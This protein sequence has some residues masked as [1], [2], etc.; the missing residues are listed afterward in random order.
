MRE[1]APADPVRLDATSI[2]TDCGPTLEADAIYAADF[3][4]LN[5]AYFLQRALDAVDRDGESVPFGVAVCL[6]R[7]QLQDDYAALV[8]ADGRRVLVAPGAVTSISDATQVVSRVLRAIEDGTLPTTGHYRIDE[9]DSIAAQVDAARTKPARF[10]GLEIA[11]TLSAL[12]FALVT[13][14]RTGHI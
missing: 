6:D 9:L 4:S 5:A 12:S 10:S 1:Y 7:N 2:E 3:A 14:R 13:L 8:L 11:G